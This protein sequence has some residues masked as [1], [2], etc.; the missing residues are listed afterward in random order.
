M[1]QGKKFGA[2]LTC[3]LLIAACGDSTRTRDQASEQSGQ[4]NNPLLNSD[5]RPKPISTTGCLTAANGRYVITALDEAA[6][7][8]TTVTY[9]LAGG[10][11][12]E[13]QKQVNRE[14]RVTGE[15][16]PPKVAD[17][18][19]IE[20]PAVGTSGTPSDRVDRP[21][22]EVKTQEAVRFEVRSLKV[23]SVTPTGDDCPVGHPQRPQQ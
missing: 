9:Q 19:N 3:A 23:S 12:S 14:V 4:A 18:R 20:P 16:D 5:V 7:V 11:E 1:R 15:V 8:P 2:A 17:V 21:E 10:N 13:L 6:N 22:P